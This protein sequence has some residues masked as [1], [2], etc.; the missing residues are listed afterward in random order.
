MNKVA[1]PVVPKRYTLYMILS[2]LTPRV[3][4]GQTVRKLAK[5]FSG[6]LREATNGEGYL[7]H[8]AM[9]KYGIDS[10]DCIELDTFANQ[11]ELNK[12]EVKWIAHYR[13]LGLSYNLESGGY[14]G[15]EVDITTRLKIRDSKLGK[16]RSASV[17]AKL[18]MAKIGKVGGA[19]N[20][21]FGKEHSQEAKLKIGNANRGR[22]ASDV[23]RKKISEAGK[24]RRMTAENRVI[25]LTFIT[26]YSPAHIATFPDFQSAHD[27]TGVSY[28]QYY[29]IKKANPALEWPVRKQRKN[30]ND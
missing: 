6:H 25:L 21:M 16:P 11:E 3:Y 8:T 30:N 23:T 20:P 9:R 29:K 7:I 14:H 17:K 24:G 15:K 4:I 10:F 27:A 1:N 22:V 5:R 18:S 19:N 13:S 28:T 2:E 12:A 26:K